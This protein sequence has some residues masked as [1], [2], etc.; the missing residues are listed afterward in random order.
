MLAANL[1]MFIIKE[2]ERCPTV[3]L[4]TIPDGLDEIAAIEYAMKK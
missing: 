1:E 2:E 4:V 3:N